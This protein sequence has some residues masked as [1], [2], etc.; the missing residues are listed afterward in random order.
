MNRQCTGLSD[1][2]STSLQHCNFQLCESQFTGNPESDRATADNYGIEFSNHVREQYEV[3]HFVRR[4]LTIRS[5]APSN[6]RM[7]LPRSEHVE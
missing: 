3:V 4:A 6:T 7:L 5:T 1:A 2:F